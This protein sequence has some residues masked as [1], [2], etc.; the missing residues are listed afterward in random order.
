MSKAKIGLII[1]LSVIAI[2]L[3]GFYALK[4]AHR[5]A[6]LKADP[7]LAEYLKTGKYPE[8][9]PVTDEAPMNTSGSR[10]AGIKAGAK[11]GFIKSIN[12]AANGVVSIAFD[13]AKFLNEEDG[14]KQAA[15]DYGCGKPKPTGYCEADGTVSLPNPFYIYNPSK[16]IVTYPLSKKVVIRL[17]DMSNGVVFRIGNLEELKPILDQ[18]NQNRKEDATYDGTPFWLSFEGNQISAIEQQYIP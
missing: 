11:F 8:N 13:E 10:E 12:T 17:V 2:A 4:D 15:I 18:D 1:G 16:Q 9:P 3:I 6:D 7:D 14:E 5:R